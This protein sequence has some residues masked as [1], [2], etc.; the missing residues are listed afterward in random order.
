MWFLRRTTAGAEHFP[1]PRWES[2]CEEGEAP[3]KSSPLLGRIFAG[4]G[5]GNRT[6]ALGSDPRCVHLTLFL[7]EVLEETFFTGYPRLS[8]SP[9]EREINPLTT[10]GNGA[11]EPRRAEARDAEVV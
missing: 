11:R 1:H 4:R 7:S 9:P 3:L 6:S 5:L 10:N 2:V 8:P